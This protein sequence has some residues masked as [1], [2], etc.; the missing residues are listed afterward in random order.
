MFYAS[1]LNW[2]LFTSTAENQTSF[3]TG[4][5]YRQ[6]FIFNC[7]CSSVNAD[8]VCHTHLSVALSFSSLAQILYSLTDNF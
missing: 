7:V 2:T 3:E 1:T 8:I 5:Y 6:P 4:I